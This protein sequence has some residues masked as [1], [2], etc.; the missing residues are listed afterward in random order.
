MWLIFASAS[1]MNWVCGVLQLY[2]E[3]V[4][5]TNNTN[6]LYYNALQE[7]K[8]LQLQLEGTT[9]ENIK[10]NLQQEIMIQAKRGVAKAKEVR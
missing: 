8:E 3:S 10:K 5:N 1:C 4:P 9:D 7:L 6:I 2:Q